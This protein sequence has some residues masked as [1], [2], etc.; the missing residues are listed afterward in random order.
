MTKPRDQWAT[1]FGLILAMAGNAIGLGNFLRFPVQAAKNGGGAFI[2]PYIIAFL[3]LGIPL[4]WVEWAQGRFGG[5]HG[6]GTMSSIFS[7]LWHNRT[8]K[9]LGVLGVFMPLCVLVYYVFVESWTLAFSFF[10]IT[11]KY[12]GIQS[13][14]EMGK[15]LSSYQTGEGGAYFTTIATAYLFFII[16]LIV[17]IS[18]TW[19][20][21]SKGIEWLG[22]VG[23]PLLFIF[24]IILLFRVLFVGTPDP[25]YPD[26]NVLNGLA[27]IWNPDFSQLGKSSVWLAAA[28]QIFFTLSL[29]FGQIQCYASYVKENEDIALSGLTTSMTNEFAEVILGGSIAIPIA[30]AFFGSAATVEIAQAGSFN[31]GFASM[32]M[33]FQQLPLGQF[34]GMLWFALLFIAGITSSVALAQVPIMFLQDELNLSRKWANIITWGIAFIC[35][36]FVILG[37]KN[38]FMDELDFWAGTFGLVVLAFIEVV[39]FAWVFGMDKA[40]KEI[41][42]GADIKI[43]KIYYYIIKYVTPAYILALIIV[44]FWQQGLDTLAMKGVPEEN[45]PWIIGA[46]VMMLSFVAIGS[47]LIFHAFKKR[48]KSH[49]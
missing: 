17:N 24:G 23:M 30:V 44:W 1:R 38:G 39:L 37:F 42:K 34:F 47:Y 18:V 40:W 49:E 31:L 16:T 36:N 6:S 32:P 27:F 8:A 2:I 43:P 28:G 11:G 12:F 48:G 14:E 35:T 7:K 10:S 29:G 13:R 33:I 25:A 46:R 5:S 26:R 19:R 3:L 4:M 45:R 9:Y 41:T 21:V 15:F 22:K 20:G